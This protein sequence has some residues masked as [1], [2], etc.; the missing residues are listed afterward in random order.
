MG[1]TV[2]DTTAFSDKDLTSE[3]LLLAY[4]AEYEYVV[5][6]RIDIGEGSG[7]LD[8][9]VSEINIVAR[10]TK[11]STPLDAYERTIVKN[12]SQTTI[13]HN[14]DKT[15]HL[16]EG[17]VLSI[18]ATSNNASDTSISG[19]IYIG[20]M[21]AAGG[22]LSGSMERTDIMEWLKVEFLPLTLATPDNTILQLIENSVRFWNIHS[23]YKVSKVYDYPVGTGRIQLDDNFK[24]VVD[25]MPTSQTT[26]IWNDHPLWT[27]LGISVL[28]N[29]TSDLILM[30]EAYKT[31]RKYIGN[32]MRWTYTPSDN[33]T[34]GAY[35]Y[36]SNQP[37]S[38]ESLL[39]V[40]TRR[41]TNTETIQD[42]S[43][44]DW[45]LNYAKALLKMVEGNT[46]R[47]A[48]I[49]G[50][51]NDGDTLV[52]EGKEEQELLKKALYR[53]SRWVVLARR[54]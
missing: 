11:D 35:V 9:A 25:V 28:D 52:R 10:I 51:T 20:A 19:N 23:G 14:L 1:I 44:L 43:I 49:V 30:T 53:D 8:S 47:K 3:V 27:L 41:I 7:L 40:G 32:D 39:I 45:V 22:S 54:F 46:L 6:V 26:W 4:T 33:P 42:A 13:I 18:Y 38:V 2:N 21:R 37:A 31:Y 5:G 15:L 12:V 36:V 17:E 24:S 29:I 16:Q 34:E 50:I 48:G